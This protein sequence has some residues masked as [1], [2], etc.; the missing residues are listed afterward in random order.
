MQNF[1]KWGKN[2]YYYLSGKNA[3]HPSFVQEMLSD[4]RY[5]VEDLLSV[6]NNLSEDGGEKFSFEALEKGR[7]FYHNKPIGSWSPLKSIR[8][9]DVLIIGSGES[10]IKHKNAIE[11]FVK[12]LNP[13][14]LAL[15]AK[16][17]IQEDLINIRVACH[18]FRVMSDFQAHLKLPQPLVIPR[19]MLPKEIISLLKGK[20]LLDFGI[21]IKSNKFNY[22]DFYCTIPSPLALAYALAI[23]AGGKAP[24][25]YLAGFDGY[26]LDDPRT[27][28]INNLF[29]IF[30]KKDDV[31]E[32]I[33]ITNTRYK[34]KTVSVYSML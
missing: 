30:Q 17:T 29:S 13:H 4:S 25:V 1:Y 26:I 24:R 11:S 22:E 15:N 6:I 31:P 5:D 9:K 34:V 27:R 33:S 20:K 7:N 19:S 14:V 28:E 21:S 23:A 10:A 2:P 32:I 18:P 3:I 16:K 12:K 8:G